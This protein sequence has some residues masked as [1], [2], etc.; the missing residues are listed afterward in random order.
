[1]GEIQTLRSAGSRDVG[2]TPEA[3][4]SADLYGHGSTERL[5]YVLA[6]GGGLWLALCSLDARSSSL[7]WPLLAPSRACIRSC[8]GWQHA[9]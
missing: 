9:M 4:T 6:L 3:L 7:V 2:R 5:C 1:M 8:A